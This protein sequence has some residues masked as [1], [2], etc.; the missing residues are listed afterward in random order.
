M[1]AQQDHLSALCLHLMVRRRNRVP[2]TSPF[3]FFCPITPRQISQTPFFGAQQESSA[4]FPPNPSDEI[5]H[6]IFAFFPPNKPLQI[7]LST[8]F[9][10]PLPFFSVVITLTPPSQRLARDEGLGTCCSNCKWPV[11]RSC[12]GARCQFLSFFYISSFRTPPHPAASKTAPPGL[13]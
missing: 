2:K 10:A 8:S 12:N 6:E 3:F 7:I 9:P 13:L 1:L 11:R 5:P 4:H